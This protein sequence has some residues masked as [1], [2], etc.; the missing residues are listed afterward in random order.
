LPLRNLDHLLYDTLTAPIAGTRQYWP[1]QLK[2]QQGP[3]SGHILV[4]E[5][6]KQELDR[7]RAAVLRKPKSL[8]IT[9]INNLYA[10]HALILPQHPYDTMVGELRASQ[11]E[12]YM[13]ANWD[14]VQVSQESYYV[15]FQDESAPMP[16]FAWP[17]EVT[18]KARPLGVDDEKVWR[19]L[20]DRW[21]RVRMDVC[22][23]DLEPL[24]A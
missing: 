18:E 4:I 15:N 14:P 16:W 23:L 17:E 21:A 5:T 8:A 20:Y 12:K 11:H 7:V 24:Q 10:A 22:G 6:S 3:L 9:L 19:A 1:P 2:Q 13:L